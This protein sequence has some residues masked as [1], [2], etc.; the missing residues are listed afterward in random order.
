MEQE[1]ASLPL[2]PV[3]WMVAPVLQGLP[4][5]WL[6]SPCLSLDSL[7]LSQSGSKYFEEHSLYVQ[8]W[9]NILNFP[10]FHRLFITQNKKSVNIICLALNM[11][12][13]ALST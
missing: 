4:W 9:E 2:W 7:G 6:G 5:A 10:P 12:H 3:T 1:K 13:A 11:C 8:T